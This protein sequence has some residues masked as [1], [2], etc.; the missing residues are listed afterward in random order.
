LA[1]T[2]FFALLRH[3][4]GPAIAEELILVALGLTQ[5]PSRSNNRFG[6][7]GICR[8]TL[9]FLATNIRYLFFWPTP[10]PAK[11]SKPAIIRLLTL[12]TNG[13]QSFSRFFLIII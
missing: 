13:F 3:T 7:S 4:K 11:S 9:D 1:T 6:S 2:V 5:A 12:I 10:G 8:V